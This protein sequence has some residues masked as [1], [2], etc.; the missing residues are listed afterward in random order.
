L[1]LSPKRFQRSN[2]GTSGTMSPGGGTASARGS[3][4]MRGNS[5]SGRAGM[6]QQASELGELSLHS[7]QSA[8]SSSEEG[9]AMLANAVMP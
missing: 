9:L 7:A 2:T 1:A 8:Q 4:K 5:G 3:A 6:A